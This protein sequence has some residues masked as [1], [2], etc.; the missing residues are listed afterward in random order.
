MLINFIVNTDDATRVR[1]KLATLLIFLEKV[2]YICM[3]MWVI[4]WLF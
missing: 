4:F 2:N 1:P 3:N